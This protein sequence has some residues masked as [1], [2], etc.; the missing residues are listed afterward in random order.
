MFKL[1]YKKSFC[2][3][4]FD[5]KDNN[6]SKETYILDKKNMNSLNKLNEIILILKIYFE[7]IKKKI[8]F[9]YKKIENIDDELKKNNNDFFYFEK[10]GFLKLKIKLIFKNKIK[11]FSDMFS[12]CMHLIYIDISHLDSENNINMS[13]M[14]YY[15]QYLKE[16][17]LSSLITKNV[18]D[19]SYMFCGCYNLEK[20]DLSSFETKNVENMI[21]MFMH[22]KKLN[23]IDLKNF[24]T[25]KVKSLRSMFKDCRYLQYVNLSSFQTENVN[26]MNFMFENCSLGDLDL[27]SFNFQNVDKSNM[28][29]MFD[30]YKH[31]IK[32]KINIHSMD[33]F[34]KRNECKCY[35][36]I[37]YYNSYFD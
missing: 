12:S 25:K 33:K 34:N 15:C 22:C 5:K 8:Y 29:L 32:V 6:S 31:Y 2:L 18:R 1:K 35:G 28:I 20:I 37:S 23:E 26:N 21:S 14:F 16:I 13:Y 27:S 30:N 7:D 10:E 24:N 36:D 9:I 3:N 11:D 4:Y 17:N 19:M